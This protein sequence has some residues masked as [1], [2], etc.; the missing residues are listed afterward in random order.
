MHSILK[1]RLEG[2]LGDVAATVDEMTDSDISFLSA[3][4]GAASTVVAI[5]AG[6]LVGQL[7]SLSA[8][9][10]NLREI[11][12]RIQSE[13]KTNS[14]ILRESRAELLRAEALSFLNASVETIV[15]YVLQRKT[16][17]LRFLLAS[18]GS[19]AYSQDELH[20]SFDDYVEE[21][22]R[23]H[24]E[25]SSVSAKVAP[26]EDPVAEV[27]QL[28]RQNRIRVKDDYA[29]LW[30]YVNAARL[31]SDRRKQEVL[32]SARGQGQHQRET[33]DLKTQ[34]EELQHEL[35]SLNSR[36]WDVEASLDSEAIQPRKL[37]VPLAA[38]A[39]ITI[40]GVVWPLASLADVLP[41]EAG[42]NR[43]ALLVLLTLGFL[44]L[45]GFFFLFGSLDC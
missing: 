16:P 9:R 15:E 42:A 45:F 31:Q 36:L 23:A 2:S 43:I 39:Y 35:A 14:G 34:I 22:R 12:Q 18:S 26:G 17:S 38:L 37:L 19:I 30:S 11:K 28:R 27:A 8:R 20:S 24:R 44:F 10:S 7:V 40:V 4:S 3:V 1:R 25:L 29:Y 41:L 13:I 33:S 5:I 32:G 21:A 6:F